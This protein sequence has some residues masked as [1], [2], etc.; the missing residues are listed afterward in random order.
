MVKEYINHVPGQLITRNTDK[1]KIQGHVGKW[2]VIDE[3][4][5]KGRLIFL[6][7]HETYGDDAAH[8][9]VDENGKVVC[10]EIYDDFPEC[11]DYY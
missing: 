11:L 10:E 9:A 8:I 4:T 5:Y 2:Y 3:T 1:I 6:L 7:Q